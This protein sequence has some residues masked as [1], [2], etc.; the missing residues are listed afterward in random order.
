MK[1]EYIV[2]FNRPDVKDSWVS[3]AYFDSLGEAMAYIASEC[4]LS[5]RYQHRVVRT[6]VEELVRIPPLEGKV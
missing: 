3:D 6:G 2:Q 4:L 5:L 1:T